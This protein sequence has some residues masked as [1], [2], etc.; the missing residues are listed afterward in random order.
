MTLSSLPA[1]YRAAIFGA[2]GGIGAALVDA[3]VAD[4][5]CALIHAGARSHHHSETT[6][7]KPFGFDLQDEQSIESSAALIAAGEGVDLVIVATGRLHAPGLQPE[8]STRALEATALAEAFAI[9]TTGPALIAKHMLP[10][11][12]RNRRAI[13]GVLSARVGSISDNR[14]G[15]WHSYRASKA[16]LN[17]LVRTFAIEQAR[18]H[19]QTVCVALHP[20]TVDTALSKPFQSGVAPKKLFT[21]AYSANCLLSVLDALTPAQSGRL[22]AWDGQEITP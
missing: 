21:P 20:G 6:R 15:G 17:M 12:P 2:S 14:I 4:D 16:A 3:L 8:K 11:L 7:I 19:P 13:F 22:F 1:G 9:N 5:R 10:R 18:T